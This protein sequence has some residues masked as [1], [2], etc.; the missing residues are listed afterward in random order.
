MR[1]RW[2]GWAGIEVQ[3]DGARLLVDPLINPGAMYAA[4]PDLLAGVDLPQVIDPR[5]GPPALAALITHL[6][7]DHADAD[8]LVGALAREASVH[9]PEAYPDG[10]AAVEAGTAQARQELAAADLQVVQTPTWERFDI[11]PFTVTALPAADGT[12]EPQVSWAIEADGVRVLHCG[13]TMFHGWW[14]RMARFAGPFD[15]AFVP[16]NGAV[17]NFPWR[18]PA[19]SLPAV[20][21]AEESVMAARLLGAGAAVPMHYGGFDLEPFYRS[22]P[23]ALPRFVAAAERE[24]MNAVALELGGALDLTPTMTPTG[25]SPDR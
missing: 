4:V 9:L 23:D 17:V 16:I 21:T 6:H 10:G 11:G 1:C 8:A 14:W 2:L 24:S 7:R 19:S 20:M 25:A 3:S 15:A 13:D 22:A 18:R 12:G 5:S